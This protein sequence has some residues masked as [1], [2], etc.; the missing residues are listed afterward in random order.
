MYLDDFIKDALVLLSFDTVK[1]PAKRNAPFGKGT[2]EALEYV[3]KKAKK[4]GFKVTNYD[5]YVGFASIGDESL[6]GFDILGHLDTVPLGDGWTHSPYGELAD[7]KGRPAIY[8]R[9]A[10]D[11]KIPIF[12]CLYIIKE[13]V[14]RVGQP[15]RHIR[16]IFGCNEEDGWECMDHF[17]KVDKIAPQGFTPDADFPAIYYEKGIYHC[18]LELPCPEKLTM[19]ECGERANMV[20]NAATAIYDG[21]KMSSRGISAHGSKPNEGD[22]A[23]IKLLKLLGRTYDD[24]A[25]MDIATKLD[26]C[27]G[28][29][30]GLD[31]VDEEGQP[32][33]MNVG[34]IK[35]DGKKMQITIDFRYPLNVEPELIDKQLKIAFPGVYLSSSHAQNRLFVNKSSN[36]LS[37]L[38]DAY[39]AMTLDLSAQPIAIGGGTYARCMNE[40]VGFGPVFPNDPMPIHCVDEC[41]TI[42]QLD[43]MYRIYYEAIKRLCF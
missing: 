37:T 35:A 14:A 15:R 27:Y 2:K 32:L 26:D 3:L 21:R 16:V 30:V 33:T 8:G 28:K 19:F 6:P 18:T 23:G 22:N 13:L 11:D 20:P 29:G 41:I 40:A 43:K 31:F 38:M 1:A 10:L 7:Y 36:L 17:R 25:I 12:V 9:G 34:I 39:K 24:Q 42:D 5:N 4:M